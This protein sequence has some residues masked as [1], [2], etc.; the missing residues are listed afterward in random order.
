MIVILVGTIGYFLAICAV[1]AWYK[2]KL[3]DMK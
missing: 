2:G 1:L 3:D